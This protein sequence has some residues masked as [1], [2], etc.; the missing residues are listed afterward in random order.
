MRNRSNRHIFST[1]RYLC[2]WTTLKLVKVRIILVAYENNNSE[3][4]LPCMETILGD[5]KIIK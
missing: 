4:S 1:K 3:D 2:S 5:E